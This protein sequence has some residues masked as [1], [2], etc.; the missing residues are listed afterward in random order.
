MMTA[1]IAI[2]LTLA[3]IA[4]TQFALGML[5]RMKNVYK[6]LTAE[7]AQKV[8]LPPKLYA[9]L[10]VDTVMSAF[11]LVIMPVM[12]YGFGGEPWHV[13]AYMMGALGSAFGLRGKCRRDDSTMRLYFYIYRPYLANILALRDD[14]EYQ[15][16]MTFR[17]RSLI[18]RA[19]DVE[20]EKEKL[21]QQKKRQKD[22]EN[23]P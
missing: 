10:R 12:V 9:K 5:L 11:M 23:L 13:A 17:R 6:P 1:V 14:P 16:Y 8:E 18:E 22:N 21:A 4:G 20:E 3:G 19:M 2:A 7:M 15:P